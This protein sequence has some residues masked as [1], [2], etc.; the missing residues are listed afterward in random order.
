MQK[1]HILK[2]QWFKKG[3]WLADYSHLKDCEMNIIPLE[4]DFHDWVEKTPKGNLKGD[5]FRAE[6]YHMLMKKL[7]R[8]NLEN[9]DIDCVEQV[10]RYASIHC[11]DKD[12]KL[13]LD[14]KRFFEICESVESRNNADWR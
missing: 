7:T 6:Y 13:N 5:E 3:M 12:F 1:H 4:K 9:G 14:I 8:L 10:Y 2:Q 11:W